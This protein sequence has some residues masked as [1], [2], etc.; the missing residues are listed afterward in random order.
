MGVIHGHI[1]RTISS[2]SEAECGMAEGAGLARESPPDFLA[3]LMT[4][5]F[6]GAA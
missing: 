1:V 5:A 4:K 6:G 2:W 3:A